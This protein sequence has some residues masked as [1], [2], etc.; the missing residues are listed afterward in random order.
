MLRAV[1]A[2][3]VF[4]ST[5]NL[6]GSISPYL[7]KMLEGPLLSS[8]TGQSTGKGAAAMSFC[9]LIQTHPQGNSQTSVPPL[10]TSKPEFSCIAWHGA[11]WVW[12][13]ENHLESGEHTI[14]MC[15][16]T[17]RN[18]CLT[19]SPTVSTICWQ[20]MDLA[21]VCSPDCKSRFSYV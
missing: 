8:D 20:P 16:L 14:P 10:A 4:S 17:V 2:I 15:Y 9:H 19:S 18:M 13:M 12:A 5:S 21:S 7:I 6:K 3:T 11:F 1:R